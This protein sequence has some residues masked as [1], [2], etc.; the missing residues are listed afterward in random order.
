MSSNT[1]NQDN[2]TA[3]QG[4][5]TPDTNNSNSSNN[6]NRRNNTFNGRRN[7]RRGGRGDNQQGPGT[8]N[9]SF[10]GSIPKMNGYV[11]TLNMDNNP[12]HEYN[13][14][15]KELQGYAAQECDSPNL[16]MPLFR[17][18]PVSPTIVTPTEPD[19]VATN[20]ISKA[21]YIDD[22]K[23][24]KR[25]PKRIK[26]G[27]VK[28]FECIIGQCE[29]PLKAK[30]KGLENFEQKDLVKDC[31]W[32]LKE[33]KKLHFKFEEKKDPFM[34]LVD[35]KHQLMTQYQGRNEAL[36]DF[37]T[38]FKNRVEV[39][40]HQGGSIGTDVAIVVYIPYLG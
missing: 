4:T 14:T 30:L 22:L 36:A 17:K 23:E 12:K 25:A 40:E 37:Y 13:R 5:A 35:A 33:I 8:T 18:D 10:K 32:L 3:P 20:D 6:S 34:N 9:T 39:I 31:A 15:L 19:D 2:G 38:K 27:E 24:C 28:L 1:N 26:D 21:M 7:Y 29:E 16:F 11:F